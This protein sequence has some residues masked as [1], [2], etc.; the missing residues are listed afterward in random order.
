V[1]AQVALWD[2]S[3][4]DELIESAY[5]ETREFLA[6]Q[7]RSDGDGG[8]T[9]VAAVPEMKVEVDLRDAPVAETRSAST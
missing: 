5:Q 8:Q 1:G 6:E 2:M 3:H 7:Q 4:H 9:D